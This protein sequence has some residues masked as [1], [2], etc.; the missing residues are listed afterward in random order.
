MDPVV[1]VAKLKDLLTTK[2]KETL[3][4]SQLEEFSQKDLIKAQLTVERD[5]GALKTKFEHVLCTFTV[6]NNLFF[7]GVWDQKVF[8]KVNIK[9]L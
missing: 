6:D 8:K 5:S 1:E 2:E 9:Q 4:E 7:A 3:M